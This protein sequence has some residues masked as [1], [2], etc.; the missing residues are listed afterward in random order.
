M[1]VHLTLKSTNKKTGPIPVSTTEED[2]CPRSC[3]WFGE[4]CYANSGP[5]RLHWKKVS[6]E[7]RGGS[8]SEF[9]AQIRLLPKGQLW[10]HNQAGD[11]PGK[12]EQIRETE[13]QDLVRASDGKRGFTYTHKPVTG[14]TATAKRNRRLIKRANSPSFTINLSGNNLDHATQLAG[15]RIAP[16]TTIL[17]SSETRRSFD[18]KGHKVVVCPATYEE[19][20]IQ[21][22][23]CML[24]AVPTR[25]SIIGFPAH[26]TQ[27][28]K[29]NQHLRIVT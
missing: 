4:G 3:P 26:G 27:K 1:K 7:D 11:L 14:Q 18:H 9:L 13:L 29:V 12:K 23:T 5:L 19:E 24:C 2:S 15:L 8:W 25:K 21:C 28:N 17:D 10:R 22:D 20:D 16:V 6:T